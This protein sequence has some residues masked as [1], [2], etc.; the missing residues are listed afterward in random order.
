MS[1]H[2]WENKFAKKG[3]SDG[4]KVM[5]HRGHKALTFVAKILKRKLPVSGSEAIAEVKMTEKFP[6]LLKKLHLSP[7]AESTG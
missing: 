5:K 4:Q 7:E 2:G 3:L 6:E 1:I